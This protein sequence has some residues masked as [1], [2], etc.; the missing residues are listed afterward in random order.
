MSDFNSNQ[1][2]A[3][4]QVTEKP[5]VVTVFGILNIAFGCYQLVRTSPGLYKIFADACSNLEKITESGIF[6]LLFLIASI[7]LTIWLIVLGIGLLTMKRWSRRGSCMY[8]WIM[9]VF[10]VITLGAIVIKSIT[11]WENAPRILLASITL[12]NAL[13]VIQ[14]LYM[15]LLL[16]FMQSAKVKQAFSAIER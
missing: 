13:G 11:D 1:S 10:I 6:V 9:I 12:N 7:G 15:V 5:T 2:Q 14:W 3:P 8:A 4:P 16:I